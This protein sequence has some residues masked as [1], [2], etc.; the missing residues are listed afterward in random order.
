MPYQHNDHFNTLAPQYHLL[1]TIDTE[2]V[3]HIAQ[4]LTDL[5][6]IHGADIG[7]GNG[8]YTSLFLQHLQEKN[9]RIYSIDYSA[10]MLEQSRQY[11]SE[12]GYQAAQTIN[13]SAMR[14]PLRSDALNC[15]FA[16]N[17]IHHFALS[18]FFSEI[19]RVLQKDGYLFIY[20]RLRS[21]N[22]GHIWGLHFPSFT[23]QKT[24]LYELNELENSL[25]QV[26]TLRMIEAR[27]FKFRRKSNLEMLLSRARNR[28][29][30]TFNL[31]T[32][33]ELEAATQQF[34]R[35]VME[36]FEDPEDIRW[37]DEYTLVVLKKVS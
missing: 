22:N 37:E 35:N 36:H 11:F 28:H 33:D 4:Y 23:S 27:I 26:P 32:P 25:L 21:Q 30:C 24:G 14:L 10:E 15:T 3:A 19:A 13:A 7:C 18:E 9:P 20:T 2:P 16:F 6:A 5:S 8:R 31:Y 17:A 34:A 12:N 1:R 29:Y